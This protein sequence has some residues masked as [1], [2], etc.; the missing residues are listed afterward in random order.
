MGVARSKRGWTVC[1]KGV[2]ALLAVGCWAW[3]LPAAAQ[4][5]ESEPPL[6]VVQSESVSRVSQNG[7]TLEA[8]ID[9]ESQTRYPGVD[10]QFQVVENTSEYLPDLVCSEWG[11][12]K[13]AGYHGC[14][15]PPD[16][17]RGAIPLSFILGGIEG[18]PV[19]LDLAS[20]GV[21]LRRSTTYH[22]RVLAAR[23]KLEEDTI[24]WEVPIV[25]GSDQTFTTPPLPS[26]PSP[27]GGTGSGGS[28][29]GG[30]PAGGGG[31]TSGSSSPGISLLA[32]PAALT[33]GPKVAKT[34]KPTAPTNAQKLA[35]A[36]KACKRK[37]KGK[38]AACARQARKRYGT[39]SSKTGKR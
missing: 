21:I 14:L 11:V 24:D 10:Y 29:G 33:P 23:A 5:I 39:K 25:A 2:A 17:P 20:V 28:D 31:M 15:D 7:A 26:T 18:E 36:L 27:P 8:K 22:Y 38:R 6:P 19:S 30:Q 1:A 35:R 32:T 34:L 3:A 13:P 37:P 12:V 16:T 4:A 9:P